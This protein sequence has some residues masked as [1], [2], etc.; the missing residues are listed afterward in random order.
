MQ[1]ELVERSLVD[2]EPTR[3]RS[4]ASQQEGLS[5]AS[6][7]GLQ[8]HPRAFHSKRCL[9]TTLGLYAAWETCVRFG[10]LEER[11]CVQWGNLCAVFGAWKNALGPLCV[12]FWG[13]GRRHCIGPLCNVEADLCA[14]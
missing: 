14:F 4:S 6:H 3:S 10:G 7:K 2:N 5:H 13:P 11:T 8:A 12:H 9:R 1:I